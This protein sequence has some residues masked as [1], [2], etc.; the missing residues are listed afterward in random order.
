[1]IVGAGDGCLLQHML[2]SLG[3]N[4]IELISSFDEENNI[5]RFKITNWIRILYD[6]PDMI[7]NMDISMKDDCM[8]Q[9]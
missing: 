2:K 3:S 4:D 7:R 9:D 8:Q 6:I 1:M 5:V